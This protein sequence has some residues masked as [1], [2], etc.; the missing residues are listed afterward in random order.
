[1]TRLRL[2]ET[3]TFELALRLQLETLLKCAHAVVVVCNADAL[4]WGA[5]LGCDLHVGL[6]EG[7]LVVGVAGAVDA[8]AVVAPLSVRGGLP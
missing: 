3:V 4:D 2:H 6:G 7:A 5:E 1:M 8:L